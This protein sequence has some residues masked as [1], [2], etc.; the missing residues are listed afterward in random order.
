MSIEQLS[1]FSPTGWLVVALLALAVAWLAWSV[2]AMPVGTLLLAAF[3]GA[4]G[5]VLGRA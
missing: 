4:L 2:L 3:T 1:H 5:Y